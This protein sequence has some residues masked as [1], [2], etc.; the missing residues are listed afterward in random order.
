MGKSERESGYLAAT[1]DIASRKLEV[2]RLRSWREALVGV[3]VG[4]GKKRGKGGREKQQ[5]VDDLW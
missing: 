2:G 1:R 3:R 4:Q 5:I